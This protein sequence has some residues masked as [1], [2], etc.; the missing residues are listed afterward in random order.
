LF[1]EKL[2]CIR[3]FSYQ[4]SPAKETSV[5]THLQNPSVSL[6]MK[7]KEVG[8]VCKQYAMKLSMAVVVRKPHNK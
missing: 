4:N 8:N 7:M 2:I 5:T 1:F 3:L 6:D